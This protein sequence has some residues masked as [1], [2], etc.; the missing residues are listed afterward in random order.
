MK[1]AIA[2]NAP[3]S[4][5]ALLSARPPA[6]FA[7]S[8]NRFT[9]NRGTRGGAIVADLAHTLGMVS[10]ADLFVGNAAGGDGGAVVSSGGALRMGHALFKANRAGGS[11]AAL[12]VATDGSATVSNTL[13]AGNV[14]PNGTVNGNAVTLTNVTIADNL[15]TGLVLSA[16]RAGNVLLSHNR[17]SDCAG[18]PAGV[19]RGGGLQSDGSCPGVA[20][21]EAF[22]DPFYVPGANSPALSAGDVALCSGALVGGVD[23]PFQARQNPQTCALGA[24]EGPPLP[25]FSSKTDRQPVHADPKDEL[26]R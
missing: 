2:R 20:V 6:G 18:V 9:R 16:G 17:P 21:G 14:G 8:F 1:E 5:I 22:L 23:L 10:T 26:V 4:V 19:F 24:F 12:S 3:Q 7:L 25:K 13:I 15:A 11:G